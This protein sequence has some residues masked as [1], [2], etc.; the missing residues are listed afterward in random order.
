MEAAKAVSEIIV[1]VSG[2][3]DLA[4]II[5]STAPKTS[6]TLPRPAMSGLNCWSPLD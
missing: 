6:P 4:T 5:R 1:R 2:R 3:P